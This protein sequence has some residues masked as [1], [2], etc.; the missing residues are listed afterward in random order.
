MPDQAVLLHEAR[1]MLLWSP[2]A[3]TGS[4]LQFDPR[5]SLEPTHDSSPDVVAHQQEKLAREGAVANAVAPV[6]LSPD[7]SYIPPPLGFDRSPDKRP[8]PVVAAPSGL[9]DPLSNTSTVPSIIFNDSRDSDDDHTAQPSLAAGYMAIVG[10]TSNPPSFSDTSVFASPP[11]AQRDAL[12][13]PSGIV[14][15]SIDRESLRACLSL[16][17]SQLELLDLTALPADRRDA[18]QEVPGWPACCVLCTCLLTYI[19]RSHE[20]TY[21]S[22]DS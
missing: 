10:D 1:S 2:S 4:I 13:S 14:D 6:P 18:L 11:N 21:I 19:Y 22:I 15:P 17:P 7:L 16:T 12:L 3:L 5:L 8:T 9:V 20:L